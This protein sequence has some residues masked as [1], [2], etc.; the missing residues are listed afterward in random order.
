MGLLVAAAA[1]LAFAAASVRE[2]REIAVS[3]VDDIEAQLAA[4][5]PAT[6]TASLLAC[7]GTPPRPSMRS[8]SVLDVGSRSR[9]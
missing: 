1:A 4:L 6:R 2:K 3:T 8:G 5:D 9:A 7:R